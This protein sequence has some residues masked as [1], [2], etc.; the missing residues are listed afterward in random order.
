MIPMAA[1]ARDVDDGLALD[2]AIFDPEGRERVFATLSGPPDRPEDLGHQVAQALRD[3]GA[4]RLLQRVR[5][6]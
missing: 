6:P 1:W 5:C 3:Q 2:A 4:D